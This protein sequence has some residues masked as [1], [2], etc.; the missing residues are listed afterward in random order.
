[1]IAK[2]LGTTALLSALV[3][4]VGTLATAP[5]PSTRTQ[6]VLGVAVLVTMVAF[7]G[8]VIAL[9]WGV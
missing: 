6:I 1:M 7:T 5:Y 4:I 8:A 9:M 3:A 2:I